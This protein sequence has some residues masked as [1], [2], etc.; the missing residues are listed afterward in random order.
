[1]MIG[2]EDAERIARQ[3]LVG[4][5]ADAGTN[6]VLFPERTLE[7]DFGWVFFYGPEDDSEAV[8]GNAPFIVDRGNGSIHVTGTALPTEI[9]VENYALTETAFPPGLP[10]HTVVLQGW[11]PGQTSFAKISL[12]KAIRKATGKGL[13]ES[14]TCTDAVL[15]GEDVKLMF[16]SAAEAEKFCTEAHRLGVSI[17]REIR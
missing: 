14:K 9:Y 16:P 12:T 2:S 7:R 11:K 10:E 6:L 8:A 3:F 17:R 15:A 5:S 1:M 4:C 13:A